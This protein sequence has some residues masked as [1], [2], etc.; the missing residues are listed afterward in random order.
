[1]SVQEKME[2]SF[3]SDNGGD[4]DPPSHLIAYV[5]QSSLNVSD[6]KDFYN[7]TFGV[8]DYS[9]LPDGTGF[10]LSSSEKVCFHPDGQTQCCI[11]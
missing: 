11:N 2:P 1:M 4:L 6:L 7:V 10:I 8:D 9:W 5:D 3:I